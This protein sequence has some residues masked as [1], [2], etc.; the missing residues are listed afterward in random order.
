M[1]Y[2][3]NSAILINLPLLPNTATTEGFFKTKETIDL[4]IRR[5]DGLINGKVSKRYAVPFTTVPPLIRTIAEDITSYYVYRSF[6]T[7]DNQNRTEYLEELK[8]DALD[9]LEQIMEGKL[10]LVDTG[11][12]AVPIRTEEV[13]DQLW[14]NTQDYQPIFDIDNILE[15]DFD[16][17]LKDAVSDARY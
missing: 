8:D 7:Q 9:C 14:S 5:A 16:D 13:V 3:S 2:C 12:S 15:Q 10:D 1:A 6:F 4:H 11:G 17:D